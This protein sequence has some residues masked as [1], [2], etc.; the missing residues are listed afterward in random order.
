MNRDVFLKNVYVTQI[1]LQRPGLEKRNIQHDDQT[2]TNEIKYN[3]MHHKSK[4]LESLISSTKEN[5]G[6]RR[7]NNTNDNDA[8]SIENSKS[9]KKVNETKLEEE[10]IDEKV[11]GEQEIKDNS[12]FKQE[13][14]PHQQIEP[15][16]YNKR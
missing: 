8:T 7:K 6:R 3:G 5:R 10:M 11:A 12:S 14:H 15:V 9:T 2:N 16:I 1:L 4:V 13:F